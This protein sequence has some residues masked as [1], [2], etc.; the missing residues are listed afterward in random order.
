MVDG[1]EK[2]LGR[3]VK[4]TSSQVIA[5]DKLKRK[6]GWGCAYALQESMGTL[7]ALVRKGFAVSRGHGKLGAMYSPRTSV[8]YKAK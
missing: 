7:D 6:G 1:S 4:L 3:M 2:E 5:L 8:E